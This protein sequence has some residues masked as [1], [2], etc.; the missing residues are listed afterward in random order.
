MWAMPNNLAVCC[1]SLADYAS[2]L[3]CFWVQRGETTE[4]APAHF[5]QRT[6]LL[7]AGGEQ[8]LLNSRHSKDFLPSHLWQVS[9]NISM[10]PPGEGSSPV[11]CMGSGTANSNKF[12]HP[13][14]LSST[15]WDCSLAW[16]LNFKLS[17]FGLL[18]KHRP[19]I[20]ANICP[21]AEPTRKE[22][23]SGHSASGK[24]PI[25]YPSFSQE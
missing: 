10:P 23:K 21:A 4:K 15:R 16:S 22:H 18:V 5:S 24:A 19:P 20:W 12:S 3:H 17:T 13:S 14:W 1:G 9:S 8:L 11:H 7:G 2:P 6:F 25:F